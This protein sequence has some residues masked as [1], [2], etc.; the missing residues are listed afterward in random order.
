MFANT[1]QLVWEVADREVNLD[2]SESD[3][4]KIFLHKT[5][6]VAGLFVFVTGV[7]ASW[8]ASVVV[9]VIV[10]VEVFWVD[11]AWEI[12]VWLES[13]WTESISVVSDWAKVF[14]FETVVMDV[15]SEDVDLSAE[16]WADDGLVEINWEDSDE[17]VVAT[18]HSLMPEITLESDFL[19][20][21]LS[22]M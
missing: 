2:K 3:W 11:V 15:E 19:F 21:I 22:L 10:E 14:L 18:L 7:E 6:W 5:D 17:W 20:S 13:V 16:S 8:F 4:I 9:E 1:P 12:T